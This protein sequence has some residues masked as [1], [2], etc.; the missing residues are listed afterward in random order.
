MTEVVVSKGKQTAYTDKHPAY[1]ILR[2]PSGTGLT[3]GYFPEQT[4]R[5]GSVAETIAY[6]QYHVNAYLE[7]L[8][9]T[10]PEH[11]EGALTEI[12]TLFGGNFQCSE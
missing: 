11:S 7:W 3:V 9:A 5:G 6:D 10:T 12:P 8:D 4:G 1:D 2:G